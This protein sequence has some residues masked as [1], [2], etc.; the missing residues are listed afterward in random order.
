[1]KFSAKDIFAQEK[2]NM[3]KPIIEEIPEEE[4]QFAIKD[5]MAYDETANLLESTFSAHG[6]PDRLRLLDEE[7]NL[8]DVLRM[9]NGKIGVEKLEPRIH[10][11]GIKTFN[12]WEEAQEALPREWHARAIN[13]N[14]RILPKCQKP[15]TGLKE[16]QSS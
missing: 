2:M 3:R 7:G 14:E 13:A 4:I 10:Y 12:S 8:W 16:T 9:P 15:G 1:M 6:E 5:D 11:L